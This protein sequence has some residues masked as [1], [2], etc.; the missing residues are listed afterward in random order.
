M[1]FSG[2][3]ESCKT[4]V[5]EGEEKHLDDGST[6]VCEACFMHNWEKCL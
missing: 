1:S 4:W 5:I 3:C 2:K 6:L